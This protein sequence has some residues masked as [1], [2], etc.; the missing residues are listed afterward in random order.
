MLTMMRGGDFTLWMND[1]EEMIVCC[2]DGVRSVV[3]KL[4]RIED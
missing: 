1:P 4:E 3:F 2:T